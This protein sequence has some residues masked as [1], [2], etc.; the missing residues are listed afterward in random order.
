M[1]ATDQQIREA[2]T[3]L[4]NN[5]TPP[6]TICPSEA[7]R[8]LAED[9]WRSLMPR[10]RA[11]A[12]AMAHEGSLEIRQRGRKMEPGQPLRGPIRLGR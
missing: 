4:L 7:A 6:A 12:V 3:S 9:G 11:V 2:I 5:R 1:Q 8:M 10:V